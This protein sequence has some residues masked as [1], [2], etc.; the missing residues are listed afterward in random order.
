[1]KSI[2]VT[3]NAETNGF[4]ALCGITFHNTK[5]NAFAAVFFIFNGGPHH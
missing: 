1:M 5:R 2:V 4:N 3:C